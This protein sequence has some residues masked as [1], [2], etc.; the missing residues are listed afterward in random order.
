MD[1]SNWGDG[2]TL[3]FTFFLPKAPKQ[4]VQ[5]TVDISIRRSGS[6]LWLSFGFSKK[7]TEIIKDSFDGYKWHGYEDPPVKQ[8][9]VKH[10]SHNWFQI[11]YL[12]GL[13]PY[14]PYDLPLKE[15][16][17]VPSDR[18]PM[19]DH[20][21][22]MSAHILTR[23]YAIIAGEMGIG[24]TRAVGEAMEASGKKNWLY[25]APRSALT[26]V[27]LEFEKWGFR[28]YP[29][30][31]TYQS[32]EKHNAEWEPGKPV[33]DGVIFD[34]VS[35]IKNPVAKRTIAAQWIADAVRREHGME[36]YV[37][38][39]SGT[40]APKSPADWYAICETV[41]PGFLKEGNIHVFKNRLA[42]IRMMDNGIGMSYPKLIAWRD[43]EKRCDVCGKFKDDEV[44]DLEMVDTTTPADETGP[45]D[46]HPFRDSVNEVSRLYKR[47]DGLVMVKFKKDCLSLPEKRYVVVRRKPTSTMLRAAQLAVDTASSTVKALT[48][49]RQLSDGFRYT[50]HVVGTT[51][52]PTCNGTRTTEEAVY[53]GP[54][55]TWAFL[56][57]INAIPEW[58]DLNETDALPE[59][60][61]LD[62]SQHPNLFE[63]KPVA[64]P[65]CDGLGVIDKYE[66]TVD[67]VDCPKD[68]ALKN[69]LEDHEDVGRLVVY[70]G[71]TGSVDRIAELCQKEGWHII[72]VDGRGWY[73]DL[74]GDAKT[75]LR[76][77]QDKTN[78]DRIVFIGQPG[79]AGMG[80]TLTASPSIVYY[81]NDFNAESRIQSE[82]RIHR[83]GM[84]ATRGATIYDLFH[85]PSDE[86]I[87]N[88]LKAKRRLQ[89]LSLGEVKSAMEMENVGA[90]DISTNS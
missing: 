3:E 39:M 29:R 35:R 14:K 27:E 62:P 74:Q 56:G 44:H 83:A 43:D 38:G 87:L 80:L 81:S 77:F 54:E 13:N 23:H 22:P 66:R 15:F 90:F 60:I 4:I 79:A 86:Y 85:L 2:E 9:S 36:G 10:C 7:L 70:G 75:L 41:C 46:F 89:D 82:D 50:E 16:V 64:C 57:S 24:K 12:A 45:A 26:S 17:P 84:D 58:I 19:Y 55:K 51:T 61:P 34:E 25:V 42:I 72:R 1:L 59:D 20:Q 76:L 30:F 65:A 49:L 33:Y 37:I 40:P 88:N 32:L 5:P 67:S 78:E 63:F 53:I 6:R 31:I 8:W 68:D 18:L 69:I 52:C 71:F 11:L 28:V 21:T 73:S 47:M 48:Y